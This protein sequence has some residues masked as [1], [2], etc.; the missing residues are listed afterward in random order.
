MRVELLPARLVLE[1]PDP[2][3]AEVEGEPVPRGAEAEVLAGTGAADDEGVA[4]SEAVTGQM[5][6]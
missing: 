1:V 5:V 6:V 3:R 2:G 4:P